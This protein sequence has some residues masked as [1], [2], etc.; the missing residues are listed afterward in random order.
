[1]AKLKLDLIGVRVPLR[2]LENL[3]SKTLGITPLGDIFALN[4]TRT[5][6]I[7][8]KEIYSV[9]GYR[10]IKKEVRMMVPQTDLFAIILSSK[11]RGGWY[12]KRSHK[13][14][15]STKEPANLAH[16]IGHYCGLKHPK[17][18]KSYR[19]EMGT[20]IEL[21]GDDS[22]DIFCIMGLGMVSEFSPADAD[23]LRERWLSV[24]K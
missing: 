15:V 11:K 6:Y 21:G 9:T 20:C 19:T 13:F 23:Y 3:A 17:V 14:V 18:P 8:N 1:M 12:D 22:L 24:K 5:L 16:E 4:A 10:A 2:A 7:P